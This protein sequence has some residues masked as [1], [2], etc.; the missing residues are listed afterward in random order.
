MTI[1][2]GV[3]KYKVEPERNSDMKMED[4]IDVMEQGAAIPEQRLEALKGDPELMKTCEDVHIAAHLLRQQREDFDVEQ[5]LEL[6]NHRHSQLQR[7]KRRAMIRKLFIAVGLAAAAVIGVVFFVHHSSGSTSPEPADEN[8]LF[9]ATEGESAALLTDSKGKQV[10]AARY[11]QISEGEATAVS[12]TAKV[13]E[14]LSIPLDTMRFTIP[15]GKVYT[16]LLPDGS[17]VKLHPGS[18]ISY[19]TRF[20][21]NTRQV[22]LSGEA[23]FVVAKDATKPFI[24]KAG[25][26]YTK[27]L[28]TEFNVKTSDEQ[29]ALSNEVTLVE[30]SVEVS[31]IGSDS[32]GSPVRSSRILKPGQQA[33]CSSTGAAMLDV[34]SVDTYPYTMWR[35]NYFYFDNINMKEMLLEIGQRY[36]MSVVCLNKDIANLR[37]RFIAERDSSIHYIIEKINGLGTVSSAIEDGRIV[38]R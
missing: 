5:Q 13:I 28:G 12:V 7:Q 21:G 18:R 9:A 1:V 30:G 32:S 11:L 35:D 6:F 3:K 2:L 38:V 29:G 31:S 8:I 14:D 19:P 33:F 23:Y 24:V 37:V 15:Y 34:R 10:E 17:R 25:N 4:V 36:N 20:V 22:S 26:L 16:V 27:V